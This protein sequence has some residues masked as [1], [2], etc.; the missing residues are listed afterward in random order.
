MLATSP[1][2]LPNPAHRYFLEQSPLD[3][4]GQDSLRSVYAVITILQH[5]L[6]DPRER[7]RFQAPLVPRERII[8]NHDTSKVSLFFSPSP[9]PVLALIPTGE[10]G[11]DHPSICR[12]RLVFWFPCRMLS[13]PETAYLMHFYIELICK[14]TAVSD[15][16]RKV[17]QR[18]VALQSCSCSLPELQMR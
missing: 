4:K 9:L 14:M 5:E 12:G 3:H 8:Y 17:A 6:P 2:V 1:H 16:I 10:H 18:L 11:T 7:A 15:A 13:H